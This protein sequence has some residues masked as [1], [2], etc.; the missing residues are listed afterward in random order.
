MYWD[1]TKHPRKRYTK[2]SFLRATH[3]KGPVIKK[4]MPLV[5]IIGAHEFFRNFW[6]L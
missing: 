5:A 4:F 6:I 2:K 1:D 3:A